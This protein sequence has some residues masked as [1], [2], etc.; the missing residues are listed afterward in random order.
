MVFAWPEPV[1][2]AERVPFP[3]T[4]LAEGL[5]ENLLIL[6]GVKPWAGRSCAIG[7]EALG[8]GEDLEPLVMG[9]FVPGV[10]RHAIGAGRGGHC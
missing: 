8:L 10:L 5:L 1:P 9:L 3:Q 6:G 2:S 7:T 4:S